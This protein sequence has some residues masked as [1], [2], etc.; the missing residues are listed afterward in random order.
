M[1][2]Q[3]RKISKK[4]EV[5]KAAQVGLHK[6]KKLKYSILI[7]PP[8]LGITSIIVLK[9]EVVIYYQWRSV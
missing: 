8:P 7:T 2:V 4:E 1:P 9:E 3:P 5:S 6:I